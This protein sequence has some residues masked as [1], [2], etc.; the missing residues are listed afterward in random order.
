ME[1][2]RLDRFISNQTGISR[3]VVK[4]NIRR[5]W[6]HVNG[7]RVRDPSFQ[8]DIENDQVVYDHELIE[9][10]KYLYIIMNKPKGVLSAS[11]DRTRETVVD[12]VPDKLKRG[13][14]F[15]VGRLDRDTTGLLI[16]TDDGDFAHNCISPT[17]NISK[18]YI[19][20][21]D[22][23]VT[24]DMVNSFA[25]GVVLADGTVCRPAILERLGECRAA[26]T[27]TEG[28]YHQVK[29]MFGTV[30]LGV[31][32]LCRV[33]VGE[34]RLPDDIGIGE[35]REMSEEEKVSALK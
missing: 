23:D 9:Y 17:K 20:E 32:D 11:E 2:Q 35:C 16:I 6:G 30:G 19:V 8:I 3:S 18:C 27:I 1:K 4:N 24:A 34:L 14:L 29:R 7:E 33:S 31:N 5:G 28:R 22:G 15:P 13:G 21:L 25:E 12:L 26:I 10:K